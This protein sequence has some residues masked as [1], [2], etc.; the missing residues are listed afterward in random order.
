MP[1]NTSGRID[2]LVLPSIEI[3]VSYSSRAI[4]ESNLKT[5]QTHNLQAD[6]GV[7]T[8]WLGMNKYADLV[9]YLSS[10]CSHANVLFLVDLEQQ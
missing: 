5:V 2:L 10:T 4:W 1:K 8:Y 6:L 3:L 7:H 9:E